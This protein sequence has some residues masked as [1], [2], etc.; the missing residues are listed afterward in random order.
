MRSFGHHRRPGLSLCTPLPSLG[1]QKSQLCKHAL[2][3]S[4]G[5]PA[6]R[7]Q[8]EPGKQQAGLYPLRGPETPGRKWKIRAPGR[9]Q[10]TA[11]S[12]GRHHKGERGGGCR[13]RPALQPRHPRGGGWGIPCANENLSPK[14]IHAPGEPD[15]PESR[16]LSDHAWTWLAG[17]VCVS[18][19]RPRRTTGEPRGGRVLVKFID[20]D[21][22]LR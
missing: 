6:T 21:Q 8:G 13:R 3:Q 15:T 5:A 16:E 9:G 14:K 19:K 18:S 2:P 22:R 4:R 20:G 11:V 12:W 17:S 10:R 1:E 7:Q